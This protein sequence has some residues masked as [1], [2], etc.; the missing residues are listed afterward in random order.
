MV[1][2][3]NDKKQLKFGLETLDSNVPT[4]HISRFVVDFI[5]ECWPMLE[6]PDKAKNA[7]PPLS[8]M[9]LLVYSKIEHIESA[10]IISSM[11]K[12]HDIYKFVCDTIRP[13]E[14]TVQRFRSE[15][16]SYFEE[17]VRMTLKKASDLGFTDFNH[18]AIDGSIKKAYNSK[19]NIITKKETE[20]ML[21][22]L[23][24]LQ[25]PEEKFNKLHKP[26]KNIL[27]YKKL[28]NEDKIN[29]VYDIR[30]QME[31]AGKNF[32]PANDIEARF[33]KNKKGNSQISY[34]F[35]SAVDYKTKLICAIN[36]VQDPT[37][38]YQ[39]PEIVDK[40]ITN[41]NIKPEKIS[42]DTIYLNNI[43]LSY[44]ADKNIEGFIPT[45]K[46][47]KEKIGNLNENPYH[48]DHFHY[49]IDEDCFI[50]PENQ[51]LHFYKEY[52][53]EQKENN[54][55]KRIYNNYSACKQCKARDKCIS[56]KATQRNITENGDRLQRAMWEKMEKKENKEE[57]SKRSCVEGPFGV[58]KQQFDIEKEV[59]IGVKET[60]DRLNLDA[61]AYNLIRLY[62]IEQENKK[63]KKD[64]IK[65]LCEHIS[66]TEQIELKVTIL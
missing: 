38:H 30:T 24:G 64:D 40:T 6:I 49:N 25:I 65:N 63:N 33:M 39:L 13:S 15:Y 50:C 8:M 26:A 54:K 35:Q 2:G 1:K 4:N 16:E 31:F 32:I 52:T 62:N 47:S 10:K 27:K 55:V 45:R 21:D 41:T 3:Y 22:Y 37:D 29:L 66:A 42:A 46:Q 9:K 61:L 12:Y 19:H 20:I 51:K 48:K 5:E 53:T 36:V 7:F 43:S 60:E 59:V 44:L 28:S 17:F 34:N 18:V 58:L 14:R 23:D 56:K 11:A 57:Y